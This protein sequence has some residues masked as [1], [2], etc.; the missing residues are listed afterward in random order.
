MIIIFKSGF[1]KELSNKVYR[2]NRV[3]IVIIFQIYFLGFGCNFDTSVMC[4][5]VQDS[6]DDFDWWRHRGSTPSSFTGPSGDHT[7]E[8]TTGRGMNMDLP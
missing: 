3:C 2:P 1:K 6:N 7:T 5:F 8:R 4:G